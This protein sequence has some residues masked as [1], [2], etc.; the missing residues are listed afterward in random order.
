MWNALRSTSAGIALGAGIFSSAGAAS[1]YEGFG[2]VTQGAASCPT[3]P[4]T[5]HVTSL[6]DNGSGT[7]R[8]AVSQG[9]RRIVFDVGG[10]ITLQSHLRVRTSYLTIDGSTAPAPGITIS[11]PTTQTGVMIE[12]S[13]TASAHDIVVHHL[14]HQGPGGH[15]DSIADMWGL[16]GEAN[17]VYNVVLDHLT[18][19]GSNDGTMD[20]YGDVHDVTISW[21]LVK[22]TTTALHLSHD[23]S[24]RER[25][26]FH[27][28]L[29]ARN[30][31]RQIRMRH[32]NGVL[33]YVNN[34]VYGWGWEGC[35][36]RA[37]DFPSGSIDDT[38]WPKIN[39]EKNRY[40]HVTGLPCGTAGNAITR[41]VVGK[42]YFDGNLFPAGETD[43]TS[44]SPRHAIPPAAE[45]TKYD[46]STLGDTVVPCVGT[47]HPTAAETTLLQQIGVALGG[48]GAACAGT[49]VPAVSLG[50]ASVT[51]GSSG[52]TPASFAVTLSAASAQA[53]TVAFATGGGSATAG[54]DYVAASGTVTFPAGTTARTVA[55][56][57]VGDTAVEGDETFLLTLSGPSGAT[58]GDAQGE[59]T[60]VDDDA[61]LPARSELSHGSRATLRLDGQDGTPGV[62]VYRLSQAA[63]ASYE[64]V[65]DAASGDVMPAALERLAADGSTV[66]QTGAAVGAGRARSLRWHNTASTAVGNQGVRV[67]SGGCTTGCGAD[68]QYRIRAWETTYAAARFNNGGSQATV[69]VVQNTTTSPVSGRAYF[70]SP[71]GA[72]LGSQAFDL[73]ARGLTA[74]PTSTVPGVAGQSGSVTVAHTGPYG[75][76]AGKAVA[77]EPATGYS[78]DSP[79]VPR[80]R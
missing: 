75:A 56:S 38:Q 21:N 14:R 26:S 2:A 23:T 79:L 1:A 58:L 53:V 76:L 71:S 45:V 34:V 72:L 41:D 6:A 48:S 17:P 33:D 52:T 54:A 68:D 61:A 29:F 65:L 74:I 30:N 70:W 12:S 3:A 15:D 9:C 77:V 37:L 25:I 24:V 19:S 36:A 8:D 60:I 13:S 62:D 66:L 42:I 47:H 16:D 18:L 63:R 4:A 20:L 59:A 57:V 39:V 80:S 51:E 55:V 73:P 31:E 28:N 27:H 50:D 11:Q 44:S 64:V 32:Q 43:A 46:A 40:H 49:S 78:F 67:R 7:L 5:Y 10:T 22:D 69:L 35:A